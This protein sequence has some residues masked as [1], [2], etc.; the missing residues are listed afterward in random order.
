M[1]ATDRSVWGNIKGGGLQPLPGNPHNQQPI[2]PQPLPGQIAPGN[3]M[4]LTDNQLLRQQ[5]AQEL[6]G[7]TPGSNQAI[8]LNDAARLDQHLNN[9]LVE[10]GL[11]QPG[12]QAVTSREQQAINQWRSE[13][14]ARLGL[15]EQPRTS[16]PNSLKSKI[17]AGPSGSANTSE[18]INI[19]ELANIKGRLDE[20]THELSTVFRNLSELLIGITAIVGAK[21]TLGRGIQNL[22][23]ATNNIANQSTNQLNMIS[24]FCGERIKEARTGSTTSSSE[25]NAIADALLSEIKY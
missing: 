11:I 2:R 21:A 7:I 1:Q 15:R 23:T 24:Q 4:Q 9:Q 25:I 13:E 5:A 22:A 17:G 20:G 10:A 6:F 3:Q 19:D 18:P 14:V 8:T 12:Q 16:P